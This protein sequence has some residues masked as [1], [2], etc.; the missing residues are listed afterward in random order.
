MS[1]ILVPSEV[2]KP[3]LPEEEYNPGIVLSDG[4][5]LGLGAGVGLGSGLEF[6]LGA[7]V[8][9]GVARA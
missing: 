7:A 1:F 8:F 9:S 3:R 2:H 5:L 4:L 6:G